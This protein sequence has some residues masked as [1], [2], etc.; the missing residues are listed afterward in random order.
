VGF[1]PRD[2][3]G[4]RWRDR[5]ELKLLFAVKSRTLGGVQLLFARHNKPIAEWSM[6]EIVAKKHNYPTDERITTEIVA[7]KHNSKRT[8]P[9]RGTVLFTLIR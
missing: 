5:G 1:Q 8:V 2:P 6:S 9:E 4:G 7:K 3:G